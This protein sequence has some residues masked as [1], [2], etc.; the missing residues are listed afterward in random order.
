MFLSFSFA[1]SVVNFSTVTWEIFAFLVNAKHH[2]R[3]AVTLGLGANDRKDDDLNPRTAETHFWGKTQEEE[4]E[5][6]EEDSCRK[7]W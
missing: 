7:Q 2:L 5:E 6:E 4:V 1:G 3:S